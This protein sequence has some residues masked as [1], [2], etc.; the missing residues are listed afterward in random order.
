[1]HLE[2]CAYFG[3]LWYKKDTDRLQPVQQ[4]GQRGAAHDMWGE[5]E[6]AVSVF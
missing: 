1:M 6:R 2:F 4:S 3:A 5:D